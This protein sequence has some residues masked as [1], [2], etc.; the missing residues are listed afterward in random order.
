MYNENNEIVSVFKDYL[1]MDD[2]TEFLKRSYVKE[3]SELRLPKIFKFYDSY[4]SPHPNYAV[5]PENKYLF[6]NFTKKQKA[7]EDRQRLLIARRAKIKPTE[8]EHAKVMHSIMSE[9]MLFDEKFIE[10]VKNQSIFKEN[11]EYNKMKLSRIIDSFLQNSSIMINTSQQSNVREM[12]GSMFSKQTSSSRLMPEEKTL[13]ILE[14]D[15]DCR[16]SAQILQQRR[17]RKISI[18]PETYKKAIVT[19]Q[20]KLIEN[21]RAQIEKEKNEKRDSRLK[22]FENKIAIKTSKE[23]LFQKG[24]KRISIDDRDRFIQTISKI[25]SR[26]GNLTHKTDELPA[27]ANA[28]NQKENGFRRSDK[29]QVERSQQLPPQLP[30]NDISRLHMR[31]VSKLSDY[32]PTTLRSKRNS[33]LRISFKNVMSPKDKLRYSTPTKFLLDSKDSTLMLDKTKPLVATKRTSSKHS[34]KRSKT[35]LFLVDKHEPIKSNKTK[36]TSILFTNNRASKIKNKRKDIQ[37]KY[38]TGSEIFKSVDMR[39]GSDLFESKRMVSSSL[40]RY[41]PPTQFTLSHHKTSMS[42]FEY[43]GSSTSKNDDKKSLFSIGKSKGLKSRTKTKHFKL[44]KKRNLNSKITKELKLTDL[45]KF[46]P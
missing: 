39:R 3:D 41:D 8:A 13:K 5:L 21:R 6:R 15:P 36:K 12:T 19:I 27:C 44:F 7:A 9:N 14:R 43:T 22:K 31:H 20:R 38:I 16:F 37:N 2:L 18:D 28:I 26:N 33:K 23:K 4:A 30:S 42:P 32:I 35:K 40:S 10:D 46:S 25:K 1:I 17:I 34:R 11:K 45:T 24:S 29:N